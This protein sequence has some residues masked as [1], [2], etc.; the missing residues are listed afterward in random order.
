[1]QKELEAIDAANNWKEYYAAYGNVYDEL[2]GPRWGLGRF[3]RSG[4]V[5]HTAIPDA[6]GDV[7]GCA[8][9]AAYSQP[10]SKTLVA[11]LELFRE[12]IEREPHRVSSNR[13]CFF[14]PKGPLPE[15]AE[16]AR[17]LGR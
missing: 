10:S 11:F 14:C 1:M 8:S 3:T 17:A 9:W 16:V 2:I 7:A 4:H 13:Y 5:H 15:D 12:L 6:S